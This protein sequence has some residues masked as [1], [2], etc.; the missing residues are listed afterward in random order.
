MFVQHYIVLVILLSYHACMRLKTM[1][2]TANKE[3]SLWG[4]TNLI[5]NFEWQWVLKFSI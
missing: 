3:L 4:K 1:D 2:S 5:I